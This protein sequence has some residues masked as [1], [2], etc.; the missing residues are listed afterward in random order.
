MTTADTN[1]DDP[2]KENA[3]NV[4]N[5]F[6]KVVIILLLLASLGYY[7]QYKFLKYGAKKINNYIHRDSPLNIRG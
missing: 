5:D 1:K 6:I 2:A 4:V 7:L 3:G